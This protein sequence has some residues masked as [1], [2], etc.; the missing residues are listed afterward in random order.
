M[1]FR[2]NMSLLTRFVL[3]LALIAGIVAI[4]WPGLNGAFLFDDAPNLEGLST[5]SDLRSA[6]TFMLSGEAG[7]TGRPIALASFLLHVD[8]WPDN[9]RPFLVLNLGIHLCN[10]FLVGLLAAMLARHSPRNTGGAATSFTPFI[11]AASI[12]LCLPLLASSTLFVVQRMTT[13][14]AMLVLAGLV[15]HCYGRTR[16]VERPAYSVVFM[17]GG[18]TVA[19]IMGILA[20]ENAAVY[21]LIVLTLDRTVLSNLQQPS[22]YRLWRSVVIGMPVVALLA[23]LAYR[24]L[25]GIDEAGFEARAFDLGERLLSQGV[26]LFDYLRQLLLP[27]SP[28]IGPF[29]DNYPLYGG[30][31][32]WIAALALLTWGVVGLAALALAHRYSVLSMAILWFLAGH[33]IESTWLPLELYYEHRNYLPSVG[34]AIAIA[35]AVQVPQG[36]KRRLVLSGVVSYI[37]VL[38]FSLLQVTSLWGNPRIAAELWWARAPGSERAAQF[39]ARYHLQ[40]NAAPVALR[41]LDKTSE[42]TPSRIILPL[43][44][45]EISCSLDRE[46]ETQER[47]QRILRQAQRATFAGKPGFTANLLNGLIDDIE[48]GR[49]TAL[50]AADISRLADELLRNHAVRASAT[51]EA[52][53]H[54]VRARTARLANQSAIAAK[55]LLHA[56]R[57]Q[58][59][60]ETARWAITMVRSA[61]QST[62]A[63]E[64]V[65]ELQH[66]AR[67]TAST[68]A[69]WQEILSQ[70]EQ[71]RY[72]LHSQ[73]TT[74]NG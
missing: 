17:T 32:Q 43:Q 27:Y 11:I 36:S 54:T 59:D 67:T 33:I 1:T 51:A 58:P 64:L 7:P 73:R 10:G 60:P 70:A 62:L 15:M 20:K 18:A 68:N 19:M 25:T 55:H 38:A 65:A 26:I 28:T 13:L 45:L 53:L 3:G 2:A 63:D 52:S 49:C 46:Q 71:T 42:Q 41:V 72:R 31:P 35:L 22:H 74:D 56:L 29:H 34:P 21:G 9:P 14:S 39:L 24:F 40:E 44:A 23:Y 50:A 47:H 69:V 4:Y 48:A 8:A 16:T 61:E 30:L 12:W 66:L 57:L 5:V 6:I 37:A